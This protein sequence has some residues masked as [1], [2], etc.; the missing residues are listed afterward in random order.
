[1]RALLD[2]VSSCDY[3]NMKTFSNKKAV[4]KVNNIYGIVAATAAATNPGNN[5]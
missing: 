1:M 3:R 5:M 4:E 2:A